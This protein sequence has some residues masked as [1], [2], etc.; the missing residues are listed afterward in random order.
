M[1]L[2]EN[3]LAEDKLTLEITEN[4][5]MQDTVRASQILDE[6]SI[7]GVNLAIDDY[8]TGLSSLAYLKKLPVCE[9]KIDKSFVIDMMNNEN[10]AI[11]VQSTID[12][13]HN[14]NL[15]VVAEGVENAETLERLQQAGC[16]SIQGFY[17]AQPMPETEFRRWYTEQ[18][19]VG[20]G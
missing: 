6:L 2:S 18:E 13:A 16:D 7:M 15:R 9:L 19:P 20:P 1:G 17:I 11:I 4:A 5:V 8:G 12:L 3:T 14:L 10:D